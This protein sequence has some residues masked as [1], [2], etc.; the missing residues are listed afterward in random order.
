MVAN[1]ACTWCEYFC[2]GF[3]SKVSTFQSAL[4]PILKNIEKKV[5][6]KYIAKGG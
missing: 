6:F 5:P 2:N 3:Q 4:L 1:I